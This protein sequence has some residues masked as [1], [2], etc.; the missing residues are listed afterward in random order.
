LDAEDQKESYENEGSYMGSHLFQH[1]S[2]S[3]SDLYSSLD[4]EII[5]SYF[6]TVEDAYVHSLNCHEKYFAEGVG[7]YSLYLPLG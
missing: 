7:C 3:F 2:A 1:D 4:L 5:A 6:S